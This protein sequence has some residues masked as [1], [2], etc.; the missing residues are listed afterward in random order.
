MLYRSFTAGLILTG[1][2]F[3]Q[4]T[5][6]PKPNYFRETFNKT[7]PKVELQSPAK[8]K[9]FVQGDKLELSL[10]NYL[11]LVMANNTDIQIQKLSV[12]IPNNAMM[13]AFGRWD[14]TAAAQFSTT[15]A[16][17]PV[18]NLQDTGGT[19][20]E[21]KT[22]SQPAQF[23]VSQLLPTGTNYTVQFNASKSTTSSAASTYNPA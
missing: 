8:L 9:D 7:V 6:F 1:G 23:S 14:P 18:S 10:K 15:R 21:L 20:N 19:A 3:A 4:L 22:L 17:Q 2:A 16:T 5:S 11:E 13:R 12:E